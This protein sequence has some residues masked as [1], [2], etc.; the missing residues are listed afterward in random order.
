MRASL[1]AQLGAQPFDFTVSGGG[2]RR[3]AS[4]AVT[5]IPPTADFS[6][7]TDPSELF[8]VRGES[9]SSTLNM[10]P[11]TPQV[12]TV[13]LQAVTPN[14]I[15]LDYTPTATA[16]V[17]MPLR[18]SVDTS[19][20]AG[21]YFVRINA[22]WQ[23][24]T[25]AA[26]ISIHVRDPDYQ[27]IATPTPQTFVRGKSTSV[28]L[29]ITT[30]SAVVTSAQLTKVPEPAGITMNV[31]TSVAR[32]STVVVPIVVGPQVPSRT[33]TLTIL[34][35]A[36]GVKRSADVILEVVD[37]IVATLDPSALTLTAG[38]PEEP[39]LL[40]VTRNGRPVSA[41]IT[42]QNLPSGVTTTVTGSGSTYGAGNTIL[43]FTAAAN[44]PSGTFTVNVVVTVGGLSQVVPIKLTIQ[45]RV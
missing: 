37:P 6:L 34:G 25:R 44:A 15:T 1:P 2:V 42:F 20:A 30:S 24:I 10:T 18:V 29:G 9:A 16:N 38:G 13:Q 12:S 19:V 45:P 26:H 23:T 31:P 14:G 32:G 8:L 36:L 41:T 7:D 39:T 4:I 3:N 40:S 27:L 35:E 28:T 22:T 11:A 33:Y 43:G 5:I 17:P 21:L